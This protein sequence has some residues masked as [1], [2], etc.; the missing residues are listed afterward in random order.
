MSPEPALLVCMRTVCFN[1]WLACVYVLE[2][3][4]TMQRGCFHSPMIHPFAGT[5]CWTAVQ[6]WAS[7][8]THNQTLLPDMKEHTHA[9]THAHAHTH[10]GTHALTHSL[11]HI[12]AHWQKKASRSLVL[13]CLLKVLNL[14]IVLVEFFCCCCF[15][16][17]MA[18]V[19]QNTAP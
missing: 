3:L 18:H 17:F 19:F 2:T 11:I 10:A 9:R 1:V 14:S 13:Y 7:V 5:Q 4:N 6:E 8:V 12:Q 16:V 15:L